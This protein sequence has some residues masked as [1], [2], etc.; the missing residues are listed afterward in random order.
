MPDY[1]KL[2]IFSRV[3]NNLKGMPSSRHFLYMRAILCIPLLFAIPLS[4]DEA[5]DRAA[6]DKVIVALNDPAQRPALFTKDADRGVDFDDLVDLHRRPSRAMTIGMDETWTQLTVP[7]IVSG[8]IRFVSPNVAMVDG[9]SLVEGAVT[10]ARRVPLLFVLKKDGG[11][12]RIS[13]VRPLAA[14]F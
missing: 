13:A 4:A 7:K 9:A 5:S 2:R 8:K 1:N 12:W 10:L 6:I 11:K 14:P 3:R